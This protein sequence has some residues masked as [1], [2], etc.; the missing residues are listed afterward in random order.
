VTIAAGMDDAHPCAGCVGSS[1][2]TQV[3]WSPA[4]RLYLCPSCRRAR[5]EAELSVTE[6]ANAAARLAAAKG[7]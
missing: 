4:F 6:R 1:S 7:T 3:S 2:A 5:T